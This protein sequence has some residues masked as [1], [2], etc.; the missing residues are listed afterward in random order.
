[1]QKQRFLLLAIAALLLA[2][3]GLS[4]YLIF[5]EIDRVQQQVAKTEQGLADHQD[6]LNNLTQRL[7]EVEQG[8]RQATEFAHSTAESWARAE[9]ERQRLALEVEEA[10]AAEQEA[11]WQADVA[12]RELDELRRQRER[13]IERLQKALN[14]IVETRRT[15]LGLVMNLGSD[16]INFD[17]DKADLR[18]KERELLSRIVGVLLTWQGYRVQ[19]WGHTDDIGSDEYNLELSQRRAKAVKNYLVEAGIDPS[20]ITTKGFGK[21]RPLVPG[22]T[23]EARAKNR[24]VEIGIVDTA[25]TYQGPVKSDS[26]RGPN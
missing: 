17:F 21:S 24:R 6:Q 7:G 10:K 5:R 13:E 25:I 22:R 12:Q 11:R 4:T 15:A 26:D 3:V 2:L 16:T 14:Q 1:M 19:I 20:I 23:P 18:P 8:V 9:L